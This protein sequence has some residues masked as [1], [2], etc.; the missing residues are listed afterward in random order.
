MAW[1]SVNSS[2][3]LLLLFFTDEL[4]QGDNGLYGDDGLSAFWDISGHEVDKIRKDPVR[5]FAELGLKSTIQT[6]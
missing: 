2:A 3:L 1:K 5:I 6:N 4:K